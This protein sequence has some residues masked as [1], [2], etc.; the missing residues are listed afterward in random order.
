[1]TRSV[2]VPSLLKRIAEGRFGAVVLFGN[3]NPV[4]DRDLPGLGATLASGY[5][6]PLARG[7]HGLSLFL[8]KQ[9]SH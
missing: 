3:S 8:P 1:L 2:D 6:P 7:D 5:G 9:R 4:E